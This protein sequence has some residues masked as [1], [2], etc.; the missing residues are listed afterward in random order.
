MTSRSLL[1]R[2][3]KIFAV[4]RESES[5]HAAGT[6]LAT[7]D[8]QLIREWA[9]R[10]GAEPATGQA[11]PSG[12]ATLNVQDGDAGIRF[13]FPGA[14][15][16]RPITWDEWF[17]DFERNELRFVYEFDPSSPPRSSRYRLVPR[18][19]LPAESQPSG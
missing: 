8:R 15:L 16:F 4:D 14:G 9:A 1:P 7:E 2:D 18:G 3:D 17:D 10:R 11:T 19:T 12:P 5:R 6:I 13:N